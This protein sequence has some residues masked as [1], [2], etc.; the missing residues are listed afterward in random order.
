MKTGLV[1]DRRYEAHDTGPG[2][3]ESPHRSRVIRD[4]LADYRR[5][6]RVAVSSLVAVE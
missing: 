5:D 4:T 2:H 3:P 6:D 1:I